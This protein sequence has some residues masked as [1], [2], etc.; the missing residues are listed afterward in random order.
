MH[1][2]FFGYE[3]YEGL[4][5]MGGVENDMFNLR[6]YRSTSTNSSLFVESRLTPEIDTLPGC[7]NP[8]LS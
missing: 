3:M 6:P 1:R 7:I 2:P 8:T 5:L 4:S